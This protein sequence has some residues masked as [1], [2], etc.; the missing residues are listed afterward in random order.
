MNGGRLEHSVEL[1]RDDAREVDDAIDLF[2]VDVPVHVE[3]DSPDRSYEYEGAAHL[4]DIG[5]Q[6]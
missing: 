1:R 6:N 2:S 4:L 3:I 5:R